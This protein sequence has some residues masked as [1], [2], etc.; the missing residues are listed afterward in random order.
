MPTSSSGRPFFPIG[1]YSVSKKDFN[2]NDI[3]RAFRELKAAG[4]NFAHTY[5]N[6]RGPDYYEFLYAADE[7]GIKLWLP[8]GT[9][10][11]L[12]SERNVLDERCHPSVL[13]WY[14]G[15]DTANFIEPEEVMRRHHAC[16]A[17]DP[18]HIT[19]QADFLGD[20]RSHRYRPY[21]HS[22]DAFLPE[23]YPVRTAGQTGREVPM[24]IHD[25]QT[26]ARS[27]AEAGAPVKSVWPIIQHFDGWGCWKRVPTLDEL[28]AMSYAALIHGARGITWYTYGGNGKNGRGVTS[29]PER[30]REI[31]S[32]VGE[33][34]SVQDGLASRDAAEQP[35]V[36]VVKGP[37][38][39]LM[40][41]PS[42]SCLLKES[43]LLMAVNSSTNTVTAEFS[44]KGGARVDRK[45]ESG[46][47]LFDSR[48]RLTDVF[49]PYEAHVYQVN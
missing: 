22:T 5:Q 26:V 28:R 43:G 10:A 33:I 20:G 36:R 12:F 7:C 39:D 34:S 3:K 1:I 42:V 16:H 6:E 17:L 41:H 40:N 31:C 11:S 18:A 9:S 14:L 15:D 49:R 8:A 4:F 38:K 47:V 30:W 13:A 48:K 23:I 46:E 29:S 25:M 44:L 32:V 27:I 19:A 35:G 45:F 21:V 37:V 2:G 24:V